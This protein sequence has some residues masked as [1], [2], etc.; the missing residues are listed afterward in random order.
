MTAFWFVIALVEAVMIGMIIAEY[1]W[2]ISQRKKIS[3][4]WKMLAYK[5][6]DMLEKADK[7]GEKNDSTRA[8]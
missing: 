5:A 7:E 3:E 2:E 8:F 4:G 6:V 1:Q